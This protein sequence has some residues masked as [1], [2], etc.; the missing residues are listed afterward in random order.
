MFLLKET[1]KEEEEEQE[2]EKRDVKG[3]EEIE[4][5]IE[6]ARDRQMRWCL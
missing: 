1:E 4:V 2:E 3:R 6:L 5:V